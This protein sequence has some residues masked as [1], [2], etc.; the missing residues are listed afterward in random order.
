MSASAINPNQ[1]ECSTHALSSKWHCVHNRVNGGVA[2]TATVFTLDLKRVW[3][4]QLQMVSGV[5]SHRGEPTLVLLSEKTAMR[6][7]LMQHATCGSA[8]VGDIVMACKSV[9]DAQSDTVTIHQ[10]LAISQRCV[11]PL[12][13]WHINK[14]APDMSHSSHATATSSHGI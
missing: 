6:P 12:H 1:H 5:S 13:G 11:V 9:S 3:A 2:T 14:Y 8:L 7:M 4:Q 10:H